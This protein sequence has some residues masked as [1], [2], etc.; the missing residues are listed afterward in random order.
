MKYIG[1]MKLS[2]KLAPK[3]GCNMSTIS[4]LNNGLIKRPDPK[5]VRKI[6]E[7]YEWKINP[8]DFYQDIKALY[9]EYLQKS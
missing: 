3:L 7:C 9:A 5:L 8:L 4:R 1:D 2:L 6:M